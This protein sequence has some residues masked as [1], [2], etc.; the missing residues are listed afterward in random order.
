[1]SCLSLSKGFVMD[2]GEAE[3][4]AKELMNLHCPDYR[5]RWAN[6]KRTYGMCHYSAKLIELSRPLTQLRTKESVR[7]T[8]M[9][10]IAHAKTPGDYHGDRWKAQMIKFGLKPERCNS[11]E[12]DLSSI[13]NWEAVCKGCKKKVHMIRKP[14][15]LKACKACCGGKF[16]RKYLLTFYRI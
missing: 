2:L 16:S 13:A 9:H 3:V 14:R 11:E 8:I 4:L 7:R 15:Q 6:Y 5:F 10:E 1:M 12:V